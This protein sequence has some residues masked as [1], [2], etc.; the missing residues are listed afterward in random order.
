MRSG[1]NGNGVTNMDITFDDEVI[2]LQCKEATMMR[3]AAIDASLA[4]TPDYV[5]ALARR[6][7]RYCPSS[8]ARGIAGNALCACDNETYDIPVPDEF[9]AAVHAAIDDE[10]RIMGEE[11]RRAT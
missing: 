3:K 4:V 8:G 2:L 1:R 11:L 5:L 9:R 6:S 10:L 7:A